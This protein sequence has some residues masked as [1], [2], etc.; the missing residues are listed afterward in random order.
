[1][2]RNLCWCPDDDLA[3]TDKTYGHFVPLHL[4]ADEPGLGQRKGHA[5]DNKSSTQGC[6]DAP[7]KLA[8]VVADTSMVTISPPVCD[9]YAAGSHVLCD[10]N[11]NV[12]C[13]TGIS[14]PTLPAML[15]RDAM[16]IRISVRSIPCY[17]GL[18]HVILGYLILQM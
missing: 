1:M 16:L 5:T 18:Y 17:P 12:A 14:Y 7:C 9:N 6:L 11:F 15:N 10:R 2:T 13:E 4:R 3:R 8:T